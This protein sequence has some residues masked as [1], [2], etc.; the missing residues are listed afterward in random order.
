MK[1]ITFSTISPLAVMSIGLSIPLLIIIVLIVRIIISTFSTALMLTIC[2]DHA[3]E[4]EEDQEA[5][6]QIFSYHY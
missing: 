2:E 4:L 6:G 5:D 3:M 1:C